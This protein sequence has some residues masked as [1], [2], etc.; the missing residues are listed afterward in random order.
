MRHTETQAGTAKKVKSETS[1]HIVEW[2]R[3]AH[4]AEKQSEKML[5]MFCDRLEN[6][7]L[8]KTQIRKHIEETRGQAERLERC[9]EKFGKSESMMKDIGGKLLGMSQSLS[10]VF[11]EDEVIKGVLA[12]YTFEH[13]E[14]ASYRILIAAADACGDSMVKTVCEEILAEEIAMAEWLDDHMA[15]ITDIYLARAELPGVKA[16]H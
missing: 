15:E 16:K 6:Y 1:E 3:D 13:M 12:S 10:G 14:I 2:L 9:L 11:V 8:L 4:A 5:T 7:P